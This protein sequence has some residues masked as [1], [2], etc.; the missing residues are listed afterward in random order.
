LTVWFFVPSIARPAVVKRWG[1]LRGDLGTEI[2]AGIKDGIS[3]EVR[4]CVCVGEGLDLMRH[5]QPRLNTKWRI[6]F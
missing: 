5:P 4:L 6:I 1:C 2:L 3:S